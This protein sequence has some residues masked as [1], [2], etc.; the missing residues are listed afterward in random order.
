MLIKFKKSQ[1]TISFKEIITD[2]FKDIHGIQG[3]G[4]GTIYGGDKVRKYLASKVSNKA[5]DEFVTYLDNNYDIKK[6]SDTS[7]LEIFKY[8]FESNENKKVLESI[9][10]TNVF[11][12]E[13]Q[14]SIFGNV[15][16]WLKSTF[17]NNNTIKCI[18]ASILNHKKF[19]KMYN[20]NYKVPISYIGD[21]SYRFKVA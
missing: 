21:Y 9:I 11:M 8:L 7:K 10:N 19:K 13:Y 12:F 18:D 16:M 3:Y 2:F 14:D 5:I 4:F 1:N 15:N 6:I 20:T 17:V